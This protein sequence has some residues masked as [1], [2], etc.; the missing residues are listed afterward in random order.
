MYIVNYHIITSLH[1]NICTHTHIES[2]THKHTVTITHIHTHTE[3][4]T[5]T[6]IHHTHTELHTQIHSH[7]VI[8]FKVIVKD[9]TFSILSLSGILLLLFTV[10]VDS[11]SNTQIASF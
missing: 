6:Y 2:Q 9:N 5:H 4:R 3:S 11:F 10:H 1:T 8:P 7:R